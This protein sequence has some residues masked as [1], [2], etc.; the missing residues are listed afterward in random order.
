MLMTFGDRSML[1]G[2]SPE[3]ISAMIGFM[4][5]ID[6][7]LAEAGELVFQQG[8]D[9]PSTAKSVRATDG[10]QT[11]DG[12]VAAPSQ[13]LAGFWIVDV[14]DEARAVEIAARISQAADAPIEVRMAM[15]APE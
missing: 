8:L 5:R 11:T 14:A 3:W 13:S 4:K 7:E 2:R 9:D 10:P 1:S 6:V 12:P 15:D